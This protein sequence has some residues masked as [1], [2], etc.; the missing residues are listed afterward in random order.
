MT[1]H[2]EWDSVK[3][4]SH[5]RWLGAALGLEL[6][7]CTGESLGTELGHVALG[8]CWEAGWGESTL[9]LTGSGTRSDAWTAA[10]T[11]ARAW[12]L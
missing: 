6:G 4:G 9:L 7:G 5:W 3:H 10:Q 1:E 11:Q 8:Q 2:W 12:K